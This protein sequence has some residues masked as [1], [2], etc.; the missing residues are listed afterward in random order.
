MQLMKEELEREVGAAQMS[1][2]SLAWR[3]PAWLATGCNFH[4]KR[5]EAME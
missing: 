5:M 4:E 3:G 2:L 1:G